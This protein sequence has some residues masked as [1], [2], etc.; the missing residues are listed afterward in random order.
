MHRFFVEPDAVQH[1][2]VT[3]TPA[4]S[5][6]L[7][8]VLRLRPSDRCV[9]LDDTGWEYEVE[10]TLTDPD[11]STGRVLQRRL[12]TGEPRLKVTLYQALIRGPRFEFVLQKG[13]EIGIAA[14]VPTITQRCVVAAVTEH[15]TSK[16]ERWHR[17]LV[18][19]AEQAARGRVPALRPTT[20]FEQACSEVRGLSLIPW[21]EEH[22][23]GVADAL[24][25]R[26]PTTAGRPMPLAVNLFI[27]P[28]GGFTPAE[29]ELAR[30]YDIR[31][32]TLGPRILRAETA[33]LVATTLLLAESGD[34]R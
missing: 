4:Q 16:A 20:L 2:T 9:V 26:E 12:A 5:R 6:Q 13:A 34:L 25:R 28:E 33:A 31:P 15:R 24:G 32:V 14:I 18:E 27:G 30:S 8:V 11:E 17:I 19:A 22:D 1:G 23:R 7:A 10:L 29:V 3:F 21:E